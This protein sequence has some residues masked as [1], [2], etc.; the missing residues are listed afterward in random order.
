MLLAAQAQLLSTQ[1]ARDTVRLALVGT[2]V[3]SWLAVRA[4]DVQMATLQAQ[5]K[6]R[7]DSLALVQRR[8]KG[9]V[10]SGGSVTSA[11]ICPKSPAADW[12]HGWMI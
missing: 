8:V 6:L 11:S 1:H 12:V 2:L 7:A 5:Q 9:G 3:Q 4:L 10:A